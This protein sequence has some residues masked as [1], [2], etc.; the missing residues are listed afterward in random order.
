M[1][2]TTKTCERANCGVLFEPEHGLQRFCSKLCL[3]SSWRERRQANAE[4]RRSKIAP[5][6][7]ENEGCDHEFIPRTR[8][9]RCC[10]HSCITA[11]SNRERSAKIAEQG[12]EKTCEN[13]SCGRRFL[14]TDWYGQTKKRFCSIACGS[15]NAWGSGEHA[16]S[17]DRIRQR[18]GRKGCRKWV[19]RA[20]SQVNG[21]AAI[22]C[23]VECRGRWQTDSGVTS[24]E[25]SGVWKGGTSKWWKQK[26]RERDDFTCQVDGCDVRDEGKRTHAHH[27]LPLRAG[28]TDD[29]DNLI[30]LCNKHHQVLEQQLYDT[31]MERHPDLVAEI[32]RELYAPG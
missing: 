14:V 13:Q 7:C 30:T 26:A 22:F 11:L 28:G 6:R 9:Q 21:K 20:P 4:A 25:N 32:V 10:S 29:L 19:D 15:Q 8:T 31:F 5:K 27:K 2:D 23:S 24:G 17:V 12:V 18:C 3:D 16:R 1:S